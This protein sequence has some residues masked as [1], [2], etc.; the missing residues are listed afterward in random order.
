MEFRATLS[1]ESDRGCALIAAAYLDSE[2]EK[3]IRLALVDAPRIADDLLGQGRPL[4][5]FSARID[6]AYLLGLVG[7][8]VHRDLHLIRR[9]R[10]DFGHDHSP[11]TFESDRIA[12]RCKELSAHPFEPGHPPRR[13]FM[14]TAMGVLASI[15]TGLSAKQRLVEREDEPL[16]KIS[17]SPSDMA[18]EASEALERFG[19]DKQAIISHVLGKYYPQFLGDDA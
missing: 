16:A 14:S 10:N 15:H 9:I 7:S 3:L 1:P 19:P 18:R 2:L 4:S 12:N 11:I 8:R 17:L 5:T 6:L 13:L